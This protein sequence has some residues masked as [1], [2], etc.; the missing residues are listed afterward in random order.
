MTDNLRG[1]LAILASSAGFVVNDALVKLATAEL[2]TSQII[3]LRGIMA[4]IILAM[5]TTFARSWRPPGVLMQPA[6]LIRLAAAAGATLFIVAALRHL[7][8]ATTSAIL[9]VTPLVVTAGA[10]L[11][12]GAE[13]G[14]RRWLA[15]IVGFAGVLL[16]VKP[17][18]AS[19][20]PEAWIALTALAFTATR[21]LT[22]RFI[23]HSTPS[24]LIATVSSLVVTLGGGALALFEP[25]VTPS[26]YVLW[27]L[28][29]AAICLYF[30]YYLGV[31]AMRIGEL[32]VVSPFRY[33]LVL[34]ALL[35]GYLM[36]GHVPDLISCGGIALICGSG[37]YL[38]HRERV[39]SRE[40]AS[41]PVVTQT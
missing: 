6:M 22:T 25:W 31:V 30:A 41:R 29:G 2:P 4:T 33:S 9:Q 17:G 26:Q 8:L 19:F 37:L 7:P 35:L 40:I 28:L 5:A 36:W 32:A 16:I 39:R 27:L 1:I 12:L 34:L 11:L 15:S 13:V 14:W 21:D 10:A 24:L 23:D 3:V 20:V 38:L 18:S